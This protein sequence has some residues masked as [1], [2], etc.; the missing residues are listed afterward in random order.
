MLVA[1]SETILF[2]FPFKH[3]EFLEAAINEGLNVFFVFY[4]QIYGFGLLYW[5]LK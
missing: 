1:P 3:V 4:F 2:L 5:S